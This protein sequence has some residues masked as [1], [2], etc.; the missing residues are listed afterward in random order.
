M[1]RRQTDE[2]LVHVLVGRAVNL[3]EPLPHIVEALAVSNVEHDDDRLGAPVE[4]LV[5]RAMIQ[6]VL[7]P[8]LVEGEGTGVRGLSEEKEEVALRA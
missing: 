3:K 4:R 5:H 7:F 6:F 1:R 2:K 8:Q